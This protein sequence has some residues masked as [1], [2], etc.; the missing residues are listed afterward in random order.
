MHGFRAGLG[1][2]RLCWPL[3][4]AHPQTERPQ[5]FW[6]STTAAGRSLFA[7]RLIAIRGLVVLLLHSRQLSKCASLCDVRR[8]L[9]CFYYGPY[10]C[11][12]A[13]P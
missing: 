3:A 1:R 10:S 11:Q 2:A 9:R 5:T 7:I 12:A 4:G 13:P 8:T 6:S